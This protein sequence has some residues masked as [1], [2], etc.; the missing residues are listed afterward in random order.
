[1]KL[2]ITG[3][4]LMITGVLCFY[5][6]QDIILCLFG[7]FCHN[8]TSIKASKGSLK[9]KGKSYY[10]GKD[11]AIITYGGARQH[12]SDR[13]IT[14]KGKKIILPY[15]KSKVKKYDID[16]ILYYVE[17]EKTGIYDVK[18]KGKSTYE[19]GRLVLKV[20]HSDQKK[21][22]ILRNST[23]SVE[24]KRSNF[25]SDGY[26]SFK[27]FYFEKGKSY[28]IFIYCQNT[29]NK[30]VKSKFYFEKIKLKVM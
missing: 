17:V 24:T 2:G 6:V 7:L 30:S 23:R 19:K 4:L 20:T 16:C 1:M 21:K 26:L 3:G 28:P 10:G 5:Q 22:G 11:N 15:Y 18:V 13:E 8:F 12:K 9:K 29:K 25:S 27:R 14:F